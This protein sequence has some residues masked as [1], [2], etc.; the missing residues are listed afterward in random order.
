M[1]RNVDPFERKMKLAMQAEGK[2]GFEARKVTSRR[3]EARTEKPLNFDRANP[4]Q[5]IGISHKSYLEE[6]QN[7]KGSIYSQVVGDG[8]KRLE[9]QA[10]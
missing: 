9:A 3:E 1:V 7:P 2:S 4:S 8:K 6:Y 10:N 5:Y